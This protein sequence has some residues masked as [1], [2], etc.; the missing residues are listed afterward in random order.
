MAD[1]TPFFIVGTKRCGSTLLRLML[2]SHSRIHIPVETNF[3]EDLVRELPLTQPLDVA[4]V[5]RA[6][7]IITTHRRWSY[8]EIPS[9]E[10]RRQ[11]TALNAPKLV[12]IINLVYRHHLKAEGKPRFAD[13]TPEYIRI[14]PQLA[15]LYPGAKFIHIIRDGRDVSMSYM[16]A[17]FGRYYDRSTFLWI[18]V[19]KLYHGYLH[20][21][22]SAQILEVRYEDLITAPE[23]TIRRICEFI[24]EEFESGMLDWH[25]QLNHLPENWLHA[26][27]KLFQPLQTD[28]VGVWQ[29]KLSGW[30]C[31]AIES[32]LHADLRRLGYQPRFAGGGWRP[33]LT[34]CGWLLFGAAPLLSR[35]IPYLQ[36]RN[37]LP[38][39]I[40]I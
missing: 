24:G 13:K 38:R 19:M 7:E 2:S 27:H 28:A 34:V 18:E 36:R 25:G 11:A 1:E 21:P 23:V 14:I 26:H 40:Y 8:M 37:Y 9:E 3:I 30:E 15:A 39:S 31:F 16:D 32:C 35:G 5:D 10:F 29:T 33:L 20:S 17:D 4:E 22:Y 6:V 12:D